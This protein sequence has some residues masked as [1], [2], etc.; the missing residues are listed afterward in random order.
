M[1]VYQENISL[2]PGISIFLRDFLNQS[3]CMQLSAT[4]LYAEKK[5]S[6]EFPF[7]DFCPN[8]HTIEKII[9]DQDNELMPGIRW[10]NY[11]Q[12]YTPA[13]WK[14]MYLIYGCQI[15]SEQHKIGDTLIE[16]V[17]ACLLGGYGMPSEIGLL[18]FKRLKKESLIRQGT[19]FAKILKALERPFEMEDGSFKKY[20]FYNQKSK[21]I[22]AFLLRDDLLHIPT[23][24]DILLRNW[25]LTVKGI[26]FKTASWITRNW[27]QSEKVAI[28]DIHILRA[29]QIAGFFDEKHDVSRQYLELECNYIN[30]CNALEVRPSNMDAIIW[31]YMKKTNKLAIQIISKPLL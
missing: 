26:G 17:I 13:F 8:F 29:G 30:F 11:C 25:L 15:T 19:P 18:A 14:Y 1:T 24:D 21:F 2:E 4:R 3:N 12:L 27:M 10:G 6:A 5:S 20:R 9:P 7:F 31:N 28:L 22:Y 23:S 16:E